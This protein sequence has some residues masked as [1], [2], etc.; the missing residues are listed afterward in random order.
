MIYITPSQGM[1]V[2]PGQH[3]SMDGRVYHP[4]LAQW[5]NHWDV[6]NRQAPAPRLSMGLLAL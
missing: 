5:S 1:V 2:R 6:R 3:V 4:Y